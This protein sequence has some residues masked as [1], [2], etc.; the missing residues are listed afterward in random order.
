MGFADIGKAGFENGM[1][2][3]FGDC[4]AFIV[5]AYFCGC[6]STVKQ[7]ATVTGNAPGPLDWIL[8]ICF[9][10]CMEFVTRG[11]IR[12]KYGIS[13]NTVNDLLMS[14]CCAVC[15]VNQQI[16]QLKAKGDMPAGIFM[17]K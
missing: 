11:K 9:S 2:D 10:P 8:H 12:Q 16:N 5:D 1:F 13:D 6:L 7:K 15:A 17:S 3:C 14:F 4:G